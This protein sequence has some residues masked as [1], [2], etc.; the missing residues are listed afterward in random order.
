MVKKKT[1][2]KAL[3]ASEKIR[4]Q[5]R[6]NI[7]DW[8]TYYRRNIHRFIEHYFGIKLYAYQVLWIYA[9][10]RSDSFVSICSRASGKTWLL[11]VFACAIAVLYPDSEIVV[12]SS[13]KEQ[14]GIIVED[15]ITDLAFNHYNLAREISHIT[16]NMNKWQVDFYNG[17]KIKIV[18]SKDSARGKRATFI[19]YEEFRLID[20]TV[21][22]S[23]IRPFTYVR[24]T[25]YLMKKEYSHLREE[26]REIFISSAYHKGLWWFEET[27]K[28]IYDMV[29][30]RNSGFIAM[31]FAVSIRH[32]IK[33][34]KQIIS[35]VSKMG[36]VTALEEYFN[37]PWGENA[38][39]Y[40]KL[41]MFIPARKITQAFYPQREDVYSP[42]RNPFDIIRSD[43]EIRLLSCDIATRAGKTNDLAITGSVRLLPTHKGYVRELV[44]MESYS[45]T[46][47]VNQSLRIKQIFHDFNADYIILDVANAGIAIYDEL[48]QITKDPQRGT[49]YPPLTVMPHE[50]LGQKIIDEL[51]TRTVGLNA[52]PLIYP[53]S[54]TPRINSEMAVDMRDKLQKK[55]WNLLV[56]EKEA[57]EYLIRSK[58][59]KEFNILENS[60]IRS[61]YLAPYIQTSL[62]INECI[63]LSMKLLA[64]NIQL[65]EDS[66][67]RKDRYTVISYANY[68]ASFFDK[69]LVRETDNQDELEIWMANSFVL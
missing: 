29:R 52:L 46:S 10:S 11:A 17:S 2:D 15:K 20:K 66:G 28:N 3:T 34:P 5:R 35:E 56:D 54:G 58:Y 13:T 42:R 39:A 21:L 33:T 49:E 12:V 57:E 43:G 38:D 14:A 22:D 59:Q 27:K 64:G 47:S 48:G 67:A 51:S 65:T 26:P 25:P 30:G 36:E 24:Q 53:I 45:G 40:F 9:M 50:S 41:S 6:D 31:D 60:S 8:V 16:T 62:T 7:V 63:N 55:M 1:Q 68:F 32:G 61:W 37:I 44:H 69:D 4:R 23:V 19:I 18:A